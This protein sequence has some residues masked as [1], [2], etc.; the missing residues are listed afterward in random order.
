MIARGTSLALFRRRPSTRATGTNA[1]ARGAGT[2]P[3]P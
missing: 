3:V 2:T 1:S